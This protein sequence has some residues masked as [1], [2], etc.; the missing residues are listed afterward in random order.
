M[1]SKIAV[2]TEAAHAMLNALASQLDGGTFCL[3]G[4]TR[5]SSPDDATAMLPLVEI[6]LSA[7]AFKPAENR[8]AAARSFKESMAVREGKATWFRGLTASG[9]TVIEGDVGVTNEAAL[10]LPSVSLSPGILV[11]VLGYDLVLP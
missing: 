1:N 6:P 5:P 7:E 2:S 4:G 11:Q 8:E 9:E 10:T 3:Y